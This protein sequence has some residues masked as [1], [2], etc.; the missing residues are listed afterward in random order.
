MDGSLGFSI[1]SHLF[2]LLDSVLEVLV[3]L[4]DSC[5]VVLVT[6]VGVILLFALLL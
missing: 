4:L 1:L 5:H 6:L 2:A 3:C